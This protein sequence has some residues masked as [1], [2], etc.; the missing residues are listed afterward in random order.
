[1]T[2]D[3]FFAEP[4]VMKSPQW[5]TAAYGRILAVSAAEKPPRGESP[6]PAR[7]KR[8]VWG[9]PDGPLPDPMAVGS[10]RPSL[11]LVGESGVRDRQPF[12]SR[13]GHWLL[14]ALRTAGWD[15][16]E[17]LLTNSH[18]EREGSIRGRRRTDILRALAEHLGPGPSWVALSREASRVLTAADIQYTE[19]PSPQQHLQFKGKEGSEGF[20]QV[21]LDAG[22][23]KGPWAETPI[24]SVPHD[25]ARTA[26]ADR[27]DL[28]KGVAFRK[29]SR[30]ATRDLGV[31]P[32]KREEARR[33]YVTGEVLTI[34]AASNQ[35]GC[36]YEDLLIHS[37]RERWVEQRDKHLRE[38][39][40][41]AIRESARA[42]ARAIGNARKLAWAATNL[43]LNS[44]VKR[45]QKADDEEKPELIPEI[46]EVA[47]LVNAA[48][49]LAGLEGE[50]PAVRS[51]TASE[52]VD[53]AKKL[54]AAIEGDDEEDE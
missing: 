35:V 4:S 46:K 10:Y 21:M 24:P 26:L 51:R 41:N 43:A 31:A 23:P 15:E 1:M 12:F 6:C 53:E 8:I 13:S 33:L 45:L 39:A 38:K 36:S 2:W 42:E 34:R 25:D 18:T 3:E 30:R 50:A 28:P 7:S 27:F 48:R 9:R 11:V 47:Q 37:R 29:A 14:R 32:T 19:V 52:L 5:M 44:I 16:A 49:Q 20:A 54:I 40:D 22:I 17:V